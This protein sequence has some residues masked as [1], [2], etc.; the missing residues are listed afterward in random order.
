MTITLTIEPSGQIGISCSEDRPWMVV[1]A[2]REAANF[3]EG[4]QAQKEAQA[5]GRIVLPV[6]PLPAIKGVRG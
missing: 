4:Q 3:V 6:G 5:A 1:R 2:L